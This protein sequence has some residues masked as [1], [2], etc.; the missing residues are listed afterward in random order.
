MCVVIAYVDRSTSQVR[1]HVREAPFDGCKLRDHHQIEVTPVAMLCRKQAIIGVV[2]RGSR[3]VLELRG[4]RTTRLRARQREWPA[5]PLMRTHI[6]NEGNGVI[7]LCDQGDVLKA[8]IQR[9]VLSCTADYRDASGQL[10]SGR[11]VVVGT[12]RWIPEAG[13]W[14]DCCANDIARRRNGVS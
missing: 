3:A 1:S 4:P 7:L 6:I 2:G 10:R 14:L 12:S 9:R 11:S 5:F 8:R 13:I